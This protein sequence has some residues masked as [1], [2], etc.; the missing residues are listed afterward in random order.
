LTPDKSFFAGY[1]NVTRG[2]GAMAELDGLR[3]LA[4]LLV[5][6]RHAVR[7]FLSPTAPLL[8]I[9]D[10]DAAT[11]LINGWMG[12]DLFFV[13]SGFLITTQICKRYGGILDRVS[14]GDYMKRRI[15]RIIPAY[16]FMLFIAALGLIPLYEVS[17]QGLGLRV[18]YH[19]LFL[20]DYL[21]SNI[22]VVFWSL[23]VEEKFYLLAPFV[24]AAVFRLKKPGA[25]Y[26][27]LAALALLPAL[28]RALTAARHPEVVAYVP[29]FQTFRSP[30]HLSFDGLVVGCLCALIYRDRATLK[31]T[32]SRA[33]VHAIFWAGAGLALWLAAF[34]VQLDHIGWFQKIPL[35]SLLALGMGGM[36]LGLVL[37]GGPKSFFR[38]EWML[39]VARL[40]YCLYL[41]HLTLLGE[42][43]HISSLIT[44][45]AIYAP[46]VQFLI[47][48]GVFL[49]LSFAA[50]IALHLLVEKPFL[51]LKDHLPASRVRAIA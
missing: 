51:I 27:V 13:L 45:S 46:G 35:Q 2:P 4:I 40:S 3:A 14:F 44:G 31:W 6:A 5:L 30:F 50:A 49:S 25:Q 47:F 20:Q 17:R 15:L 42:A 43:G 38:A 12:V 7:P 41:V 8:P 1:F 26:L 33:V 22:I 48:S 9:G 11:P 24:L 21:P 34:T 18:V 37:G 23:G 28:L 10:W 39:I 16:Y 29:Y 36:L 32:G 19:M